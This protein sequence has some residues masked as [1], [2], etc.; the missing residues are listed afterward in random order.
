MH[1]RDIRRQHTLKDNKQKI[2]K[3]DDITSHCFGTRAK[4]Q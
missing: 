4:T 1:Y 2:Y 3:E